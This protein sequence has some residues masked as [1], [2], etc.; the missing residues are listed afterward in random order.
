MD[1]L[2]QRTVEGIAF[3]KIPLNESCIDGQPC[4]TGFIAD[5][6]AEYEDAEDQGLLFKLS[7]KVGDQ[8]FIVYDGDDIIDTQTI[9]SIGIG[10]DGISITNDPYDGHICYAHELN[11]ISEWKSVYTTREAA[12]EV[13]KSKIKI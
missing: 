9:Y 10:A 4:F 7:C 12:E 5:R 6:I 3:T 11:T 1:R 13:L 8:V 2:S